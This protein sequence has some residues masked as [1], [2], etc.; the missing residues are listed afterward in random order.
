MDL[1]DKSDSE[2][3]A[4]LKDTLARVEELVQSAS[5]KFKQSELAGWDESLYQNGRELLADSERLFEETEPISEELER[6][7]GPGVFQELMDLENVHREEFDQRW[8]RKDLTTRTV[9]VR[10]DMDEILPQALEDLLSLVPASWWRYQQSLMNEEWRRIVLQP[11]QL[12]GRERWGADFTNIHRYAYYLSVANDH[13]RKEPLLDIYATARAVP[14]ICSL[15]MSLETLKNVKGA[16][17][18]LRELCKA[19]SA[20]TDAR[21]FELLVAAAFA[22]MGHDVEFIETSATKTPDL[23]LND[24]PFPTVVECKR[25]QVLNAYEIEEFSLMRE[26]FATLCAEREELGLLGE[27]AI[28]FKQE[29]K[30][31]T[32]A[33]V[34]Q[35]IRD[36]TKSLSPYA[37]VK[38]EW[39]SLRLKPVDVLKDFEPTRL[40]SPEFL[41]NVF[42]TDLEMDEFDGICA[43]AKNSW[44]PVVDQAELPFLLKWTSNSDAAIERKLQTVR[45]L[46]IE[47]VDQ[48][49]TG[50]AGLIYLAYEEGHR[51]TLADERTEAIRKLAGTI[52]FK[53]RGISIPM[54]LIS[55]LFPNTVSEGRPD[56]IESV[57]PQVDGDEEDFSIW[58][59]EMPTRIVVP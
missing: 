10:S 59:R 12:C 2:L 52:Y 49:P 42:G 36:M 54:T 25:Q 56:L 41:H 19:P 57:I 26:A 3:A 31:V 16:D 4:M 32:V 28:E 24:M 34:V 17:L 58:T 22:R 21:I 55:R 8:H 43:I 15:G 18:K 38:T 5:E 46:W 29:I 51:P 40:Y 23:R 45:N 37:A 20:E 48:I 44:G 53:R 47:A 33:A 27:L 35:G 6:R 14:Q 11:L 1:Q 30:H 7:L 13:L 50:E 39:G 9:P